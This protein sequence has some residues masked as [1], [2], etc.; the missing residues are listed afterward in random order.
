M[1]DDEPAQ[2][3]RLLDRS[4]VRGGQ[5]PGA[6]DVVV[7]DVPELGAD[8]SRKTGHEQRHHGHE[9]HQPERNREDFDADR[10]A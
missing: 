4:D 10:D 3:Q 6:W 8:L 7:D 5:G 2:V 1:R 9:G